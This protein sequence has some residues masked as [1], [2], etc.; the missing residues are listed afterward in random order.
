MK[1]ILRLVESKACPIAKE[2]RTLFFFFF[3][4]FFFLRIDVCRARFRYH[5]KRPASKDFQG[6]CDLVPHPMA[7][8]VD[9]ATSMGIS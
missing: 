3:F 6:N 9:T 2:R 4:F 5:V 7:E 1:V 8:C